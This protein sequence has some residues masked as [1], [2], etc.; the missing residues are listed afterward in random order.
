MARRH[1]SRAW[2]V[3]RDY[4]RRV[5][6][7]SGEDNIFFLSGGIAF[8]ILLA[9][10]PFALLL[11]TGLAYFLNQSAERSAE[12][13]SQLIDR[14]LPGT[15]LDGRT[16]IHDLIVEVVRTRGKVGLLSAIGFVWFSTRLFGSLRSVLADVF[17]IEQDR[18]MVA[19]KLFDVQITVLSS[20]LVVAYTGL[21]AYLAIATTR[22]VALLE[23]L[24]VRAD[25]VGAFGYWTGRALAFGVIAA[26]FFALYKFL[27]NRRIRWQ[28]ALL[29]A[30]VA[31]ALL[32]L[33]KALFAAYIRSFNPGGLYTG[34]LAG[35]VIVVFWVYYAAML[36]IIGGEVA[37]VYELRR[38]RRTQRA[39]L[40]D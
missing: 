5:W 26:M 9:V 23:R 24:G 6:D 8:N 12:T 21:S 16:M 40:E 15:L 20:L 30:M 14:L 33:A 39:V 29:G 11:V 17:D 28:T 7:N 18:G 38:V 25:V 37:Q 35:F 27:P 31:G 1:A 10:V 13:V 4:G 19:G 34:T 2:W 22:G 32:E 3:L 36:F